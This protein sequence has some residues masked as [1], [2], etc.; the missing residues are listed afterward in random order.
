MK[1]TILLLLLILII[2]YSNAS[3]ISNENY[4]ALT[5]FPVSGSG[6]IS[7]EN[8]SARV[9]I[10]EYPTFN[11]SNENYSAIIGIYVLK[12]S[13][14]EQ[15]IIL[16]NNGYLPEM[17][18]GFLKDFRLFLLFLILISVLLSLVFG[19]RRKRRNKIITDLFE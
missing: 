5:E 10:V 11:I 17:A 9:L 18:T 7:N 8:Y 14:A 13:E 19:R 16:E 1:K 3:N 12:T 15:T 2:P 4:S 6:N